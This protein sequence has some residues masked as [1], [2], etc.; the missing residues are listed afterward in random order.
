M[1][2]FKSF[3]LSDDLQGSLEKMNYTEP[4]PVQSEAIPLAL[5]GRDI[6]GSAQTGTGKTAAFSIPLVEILLRSPEACGLILPPTR[7]LAKQVMDVIHQ[8]LGR[9]SGINTAFIIGGEA[10]HKQ[11]AQL[12][13]NPRIIVGTPGRI[14]DHLDRGSMDLSNT[15]FLVL[16][17]TD[18]MLDMGFGIQLDRIVEFLPEERQTLM[19]SATLPDDII[20][21]S[22]KYMNN[23]E[24]IAVGATNVVAQNIQQ[25]VIHIEQDKKY[26]ELTE[27]LSQREG[28]VI[29]FVKTKHGADRMSKNLRRDGFTADALHG[30]LRQNK[31]D[32]VMRNYRNQNFR[33]LVATDIAA[34]GLD[35]PHIEHVINY[36]LPQVAEDYIHRMGRTARAGAEG[37]ALCFISPQD[38][39]KWHAIEC[40]LYPD[41]ISHGAPMTKKGNK[42]RRKAFKGGSDKPRAGRGGRTDWS[43]RNSAGKNS[44]G[45]G[46]AGKSSFRGKS[47]KS[48]GEK[49]SKYGSNKSESDASDFSR[50]KPGAKS[51]KQNSSKPNSSGSKSSDF[52]SSD[53]KYDKKAKSD[54]PR[55]RN[56]K[57]YKGK[58][59]GFKADRPRSND[60]PR[61]RDD[62]PYRSKSGGF[63][64]GGFKAG[65]NKSGGF[66]SDRP[67]TEGGAK[68]EGSKS[69]RTKPGGAKPKGSKSR[70]NFKVNKS[71]KPR[72]AVSKSNGSRSARH[73]NKG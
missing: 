42:S 48:Y 43:N 51:F 37:S 3:D 33:I 59:G 60:E 16:D 5:E 56:D 8:L 46:S 7:E 54:K 49:S 57:P 32:K 52:K 2:N 35:V 29:I 40:L 39:R 44:A 13:Q 71:G 65:G 36:D 19:F 63:K 30:D 4:T 38:S 55:S 23:P 14:N 50:S 20:K 11:F 67:R 73:P 28:T 69:Y 18:R 64:T 58:S 53:F 25:D 62:K 22:K 31:R 1:K 34:R 15:G 26:H 21:L 45:K 68:S 70:P 17:E 10:M 27:Q 66:K 24:R 41:A 47:R 12:K 6:L 72:S 61:S 9:N